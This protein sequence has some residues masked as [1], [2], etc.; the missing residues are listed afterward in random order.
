[1]TSVEILSKEFKLTPE[2]I[3]SLITLSKEGNTGSYLSRYKKDELG[4]LNEFVIY[5]ILKRH[6]DIQSLEN[7]RNKILKTLEQQSSMTH[8]KM[9][10]ILLQQKQ[11]STICFCHSNRTNKA[12]P[13][14][15]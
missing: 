9:K 15:P 6:Q 3:G 11:S 7:K 2:V 12:S 1:M 4:N 8:S 13:S 10:S 5:K 14:M